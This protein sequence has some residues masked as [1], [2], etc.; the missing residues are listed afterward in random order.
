MAKD[1]EYGIDPEDEDVTPAEFVRRW[2]EAAA[3][4]H[5]GGGAVGLRYL[6]GQPST[7]RGTVSQTITRTL[8]HG[9]ARLLKSP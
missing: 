3:A 2:Q 5:A 9:E 1:D 6:S 8:P 7:Y 4:G